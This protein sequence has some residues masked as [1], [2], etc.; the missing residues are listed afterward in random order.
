M[1]LTEETAGECDAAARVLGNLRARKSAHR[2]A[3]RLIPFRPGGLLN[4]A[5]AHP[6]S[7]PGHQRAVVEVNALRDDLADAIVLRRLEDP[8]TIKTALEL[9]VLRGT[10]RSTSRARKFIWFWN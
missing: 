8:R 5:P 10:D 2:E 9:L 6:P 3:V 1:D 7:A 4:P